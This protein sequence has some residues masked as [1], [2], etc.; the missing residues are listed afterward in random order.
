LFAIHFLATASLRNLSRHAASMQ[1]LTRS[2]RV[3]VVIRPT[4]IRY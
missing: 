2:L 3:V 4:A 1:E